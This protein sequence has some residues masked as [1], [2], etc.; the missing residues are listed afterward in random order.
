MLKYMNSV[1]PLNS[2]AEGATHA[3]R[4]SGVVF[5]NSAQNAKNDMIWLTLF[6]V[7]DELSLSMTLLIQSPASSNF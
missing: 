6:D 4:R 2:A 1:Q 3:F 5:H 7:I